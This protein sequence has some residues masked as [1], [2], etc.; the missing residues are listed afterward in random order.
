MLC[1]AKCGF[2]AANV[3][4]PATKEGFPAVKE[5]FAPTTRMLLAATK[6][7]FTVVNCGFCTVVGVTGRTT[8]PAAQVVTA[9]AATSVVSPNIL[10][11]LLITASFS[12]GCLRRSQ[13]DEASLI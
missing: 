10:N 13:A 7:G 6:G 5:G 11:I 1:E 4:F 12:F 3:G 9:A 8:P 2:D